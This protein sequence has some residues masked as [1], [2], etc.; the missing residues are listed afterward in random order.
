MIVQ[1]GTRIGLIIG[2]PVGQVQSPGLF[3]RHF[4]SRDEDAVLVPLDIAPDR[5]AAFLQAMRGM[6]NVSGCIVTVPH[7]VAVV[8]HLDQLSD[9]AQ[10]LRAANV[11]RRDED[12]RLSGDNVDGIGFT[13]AAGPHGY[14]AK[15]STALVIGAG[16]VGSAIADALCAAGVSRLVLTDLVA[17]RAAWLARTLA[18]SFPD[19]ALM[20][21]GMP[22]DLA[23]FDLVAN[24]TPVGMGAQAA[25]PMS[26]SLIATLNPAAIVA[27]VVTEPAETALLRAAKARGCRVQAG[28]E[29][30]AAQMRALGRFMGMMD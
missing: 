6:A 4:A 17:E 15:G 16:G 11:I 18:T 3:N 12:G 26:K 27:D 29:M 30:A 22:E 2:H 19:V 9:V 20:A 28:P 24:A 14:D 21:A 23:G 7:K 13:M 10:R 8:P 1:G 25:L 5:L